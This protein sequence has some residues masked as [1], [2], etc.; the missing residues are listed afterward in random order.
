[1]PYLGMFGVRHDIRPPNGLH[2]AFSILQLWNAYQLPSNTSRVCLPF[3]LRSSLTDELHC[4]VQITINPMAGLEELHPRHHV[5]VVVQE[6]S[7]PFQTLPSAKDVYDQ[8]LVSEEAASVLFLLLESAVSN[9]IDEIV[10]AEGSIF[11]AD[12]D[13]LK[14]FRITAFMKSTGFMRDV[15]HVHVDTLRTSA[16]TDRFVAVLAAIAF[17]RYLKVALTRVAQLYLEE[18]QEEDRRSMWKH[19]VVVWDIGCRSLA[20]ALIHRRSDV[21]NPLPPYC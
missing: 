17:A 10:A 14:A 9:Y 12:L 16:L 7:D 3:F 5:T 11:D 20:R 6:I 19:L 2:A 1:M 8:L 4:I 18:A 21:S 15:A 13:L